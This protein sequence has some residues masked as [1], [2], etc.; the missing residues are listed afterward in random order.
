MREFFQGWRRKTIV[1]TLVLACLL[2]AGW[3]RSF[4]TFDA[5]YAP[6]GQLISANGGIYGELSVETPLDFSFFSYGSQ[7]P[8]VKGRAD[9]YNDPNMV[10]KFWHWR[11]FGFAYGFQHAD[12]EQAIL[13]IIPYW[14]IVIPLTLVSA[15]LLLSKPRTQ[16]LKG[17][18]EPMPSEET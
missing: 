3:M 5:L 1:V 18:S 8:N 13:C 9:Y 7:G 15:Y 14:S 17:I 11:F 12:R 6:I 10:R 2:M 4:I 16:A